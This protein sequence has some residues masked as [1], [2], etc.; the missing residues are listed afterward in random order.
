[1]RNCGEFIGFF[2]IDGLDG[3]ACGEEVEDGQY[4][5]FGEDA[6]LFAFCGFGGGGFFF[7]IRM[8]V[9]FAFCE[10]GVV[11]V[12]LGDLEVE[13]GEGR[14][15]KKGRVADLGH[16]IDKSFVEI[17]LCGYE[18]VLE[19]LRPFEKKDLI[20]AVDLRMLILADG[21]GDKW[22]EFYPGIF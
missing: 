19:D 2:E 10:G 5:F 22:N 17:G 20:D 12:V 9:E 18:E 11:L 4:L 14:F 21:I 7:D 1:M 8:D 6:F 16:C 13:V 15:R 3:L